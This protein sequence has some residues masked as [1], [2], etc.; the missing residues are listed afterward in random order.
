MTEI[1]NDESLSSYEKLRLEN[2][3]RNEEF[4]KQVGLSPNTSNIRQKSSSDVKK[5]KNTTAFNDIIE[6]TRKSRRIEALPVVSYDMKIIDKLSSI[7]DSND[8]INDNIDKI[9]RH[10][11][12]SSGPRPPPSSDMSRAIN[13]QLS[14]VLSNG[15]GQHIAEYGKAAVMAMCN[16]G[17]VPRFSKYSG[18]VEW[19]NAIFLWVNLGHDKSQYPNTF[20]EQGKYITWFGGSKMHEDSE[21][22]KRLITLGKTSYKG[23]DQ[24]I[25]FVRKEG[26]S[27]VCL[28]RLVHVDYKLDINPVTFRWQLLDYDNL[29]DIDFFKSIIKM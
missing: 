23:D 10:K 6:P 16:N 9:K 2:I 21:V 15:L 12:T 20:S 27:Y 8:N 29:N 22:I 28:G 18:V 1:E 14:D 13:A 11:P 25:L 26:E 4:L 24:I 17:T 19:K 5:K 7:E 3:K